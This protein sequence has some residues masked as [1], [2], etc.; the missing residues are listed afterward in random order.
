M[1]RLLINDQ[2]IM[3]NKANEIWNRFQ[4]SKNQTSFRLHPFPEN[5]ER[6]TRKSIRESE[7]VYL[8]ATVKQFEDWVSPNPKTSL[9]ESNPFHP[10]DRNRFWAYSDYKEISNLLNPNKNLTIFSWD[11]LANCES[12]E[13]NV[14][15]MASKM[16]IG[17]KGAHTALHFDTYGVNLVFQVKGTKVWRFWSP[18]RKDM[19]PTRIPF[20]ESSVFSNWDMRA[21]HIDEIKP[22]H[23]HCRPKPD[24]EVR[25]TPGQG[26]FVPHH[27]WHDVECDSDICASINIWLSATPPHHIPIASLSPFPLSSSSSSSSSS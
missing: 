23:R 22:H 18:D 25:L 4:G 3:E 11:M 8:E 16:W 13:G 17:K 14:D 27:W 26:L 10:F 12:D 24:L 19:K 15:L 7:C 21:P 1:P 6:G 20:E 5:V 2:N 9:S